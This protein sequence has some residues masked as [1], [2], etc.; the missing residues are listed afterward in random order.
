MGVRLTVCGDNCGEGRGHDRVLSRPS[1]AC[2]AGRRF[3]VVGE[4]TVVGSR[5]PGRGAA[6]ATDA[7]GVAACRPVGPGHLA[8]SGTCLGCRGRDGTRCK[9]R[10][11]SSSHR[12][13]QPRA[14]AAACRPA[15]RVLRAPSRMFLASNVRGKKGCTPRLPSGWRRRRWLPG[16][17]VV[18]A[19][20][21][22]ALG[23][24][25][26][27]RISPGSTAHQGTSYTPRLPSGWRRR[28]WLPAVAAGVAVGRHCRSPRGLG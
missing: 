26:L 4:T 10:P 5:A 18:A 22:T 25:V 9:S 20:R 12:P 27:S 15:C 8:N 6:G 23:P 7:A 14:A 21:P 16:A 3:R 11:R 13:P 1:N 17:A 2:G 24:P 19:C 28:R